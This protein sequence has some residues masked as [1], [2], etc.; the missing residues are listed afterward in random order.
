MA[1]HHLAFRASGSD[2]PMLN[3]IMHVIVKKILVDQNFCCKIGR[4]GFE[5][6]K[7]HAEIHTD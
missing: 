6:M 3:A 1:T 5:A 4:L 7:K 2:V